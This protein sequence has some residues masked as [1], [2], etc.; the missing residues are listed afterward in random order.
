MSFARLAHVAFQV[1]DLDT[2]L[3]FYRDGLG[4]P[5]RFRI[6]FSELIAWKAASPGGVTDPAETL[7]LIHARG[8]EP[9]LVYLEIAPLQ[10]LELF[11]ALRPEALGDPLA[12]D[13]H[14][15]LCLQVDDAA[16]AHAELAARGIAADGPPAAGPDHS[17]QFW[18]TD[19]DGNRIE[20]MQYRDRSYQLV[21][22]V[23]PAAGR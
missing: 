14:A 6:P 2:A 15:H 4:L 22:P 18:L 9:W 10:Y 19:P 7:A 17:L 3:A 21:P 8:D 1:R 23:R 16:A 11:P 20:V 12:A 13:S 5:E